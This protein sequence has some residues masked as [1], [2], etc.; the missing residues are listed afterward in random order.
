MIDASGSIGARNWLGRRARQ[1]ANRWIENLIEE[2][3]ENKIKTQTD[4]AIQVVATH[5][6]PSG[7][8]LE[9]KVA[10]VELINILRPTVAAARFIIFAAV[11]LHKYP[12]VSQKLRDNNEEYLSF[13]VHEVRRF[14][15]FFPFV[16]ALVSNKFNW[17][18]Y[19]FPKGTRVLLD[20]YGTNRD[21]RIWR[22]PHLFRPERF[23]EADINAFN[24]IP[25]GGGDYHTNHR[26]P[27]EDLTKELIKTALHFLLHDMQYEVPEQNMH[28]SLSRVPAIPRSRFIISNVMSSGRHTDFAI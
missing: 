17:E 27:G 11:A 9:K 19:T 23:H 14:Y 16:G 18:G 24:I 20:L 6:D 10:A 8:L 4:S 1:R 2:V 5:R 3:R 7:Q 28:I 22:D 25:H 13:F 26:C 15:P 21:G 12:H